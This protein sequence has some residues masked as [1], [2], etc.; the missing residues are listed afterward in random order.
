MSIITKYDNFCGNL[1]L[2]YWINLETVTLYVQSFFNIEM[3]QVVE[4]LLV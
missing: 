2:P 1:T 3:P 4:I